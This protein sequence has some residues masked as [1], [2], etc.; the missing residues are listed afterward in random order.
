[1]FDVLYEASLLRSLTCSRIPP[2]ER[3]F[4]EGLLA[5]LRGVSRDELLN[6]LCKEDAYGKHRNG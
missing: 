4:L 3:S 1:M 5:D 2:E 6:I